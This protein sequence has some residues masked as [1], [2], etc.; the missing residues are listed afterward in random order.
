MKDELNILREKIDSLDDKILLLIEE[1]IKITEKIG[2]AKK[3]LDI[4]IRDANREKEK[5]EKLKAKTSKLNIPEI[6]IEK[7][8]DA[9]FTISEK[10]QK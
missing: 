5:I 4:P 10:V 7:I 6:L 1:R 8:W 2:A 9:F 3:K